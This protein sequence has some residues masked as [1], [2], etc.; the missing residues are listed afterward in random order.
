MSSVVIVCASR[1]ERGTILH[2]NGAGRLARD[3]LSACYPA[4]ATQHAHLVMPGLNAAGG[5]TSWPVTGSRSGRISNAATICATASQIARSAN[6]CPGH[7]LL[8]A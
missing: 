1:S 6:A 7:T 8:I 4:M 5:T 3:T 2:M